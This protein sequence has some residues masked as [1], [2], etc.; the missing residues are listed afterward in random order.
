[1]GAQLVEIKEGRRLLRHEPQDYHEGQYVRIEGPAGCEVVDA[2]TCGD[3]GRDGA[4]V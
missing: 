2:A 3:G 1:M 4:V